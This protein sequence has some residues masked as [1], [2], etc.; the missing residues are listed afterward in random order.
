TFEQLRLRYIGTVDRLVAE[1]K[2]RRTARRVGDRDAYWAP[3]T[4]VLTEAM[5]LGF[6][7]RQPLPSARRYLES[8]REKQYVLTSEG[9]ALAAVAES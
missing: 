1:G 2:G 6:V 8:Y 3:T 5:R 9:G 4:E 7:Q